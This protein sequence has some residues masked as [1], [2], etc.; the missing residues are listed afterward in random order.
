MAFGRKFEG[1]RMFWTVSP[2]FEKN[3]TEM[4]RG[5]EDT[6]TYECD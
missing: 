4:H 2:K 6:E 1:L 3:H 5:V